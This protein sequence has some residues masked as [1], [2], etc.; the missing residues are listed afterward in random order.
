MATD[1]YYF[2]TSVA[3]PTDPNNAWT[4]DFRAFNG[5]TADNTY[6]NVYGSSNYL[7]GTGTTAPGSGN[8]ITKVEVRLYGHSGNVPNI[9]G[10]IYNGA[11]RLDNGDFE[12]NRVGSAGWGS[13]VELNAPA[14]GGWTWAKIQTLEVRFYRTGMPGI[15][16][17]RKI[18][19]KVTSTFG[20]RGDDSLSIIES[21]ITKLTTYRRLLTD[22]LIVAES[23]A[24]KLTTY[25]VLVSD[26]IVLTESVRIFIGLEVN[27]ADTVA[28]TE[29]VRVAPILEVDVADL[30]TVAESLTRSLSI[31][32]YFNDSTP[33]DPNNVWDNDSS[34]FDGFT[35]TDAIGEVPGSSNYL[36]GT[37]TTS[38]DNGHIIDK[39]E[40]R[41]NGFGEGNPG[42][43]GQVWN[44]PERIDNSDLANWLESQGWGTLAEL[45]IPAVGWDWLRV[46]N[47]EI[48]FYP[49]GAG[50]TSHVYKVE[51]VV[52]SSVAAVE[53]NVNDGVGIVEVILQA[54]SLSLNTNDSIKVTENIIPTIVLAP[55]L[56]E[57][58]SITE[59]VNVQI[60]NVVLEIS[61]FSAVTVTENI[62]LELTHIEVEVVDNLTVAEYL[63]LALSLSVTS[64]DDLSITETLT[65]ILS[66]LKV[67]VND[68]LSI[69]ES[70]T[71]K[72]NILE[73]D[74]F[75]TAVV[76]ENIAIELTHVEVE[77]VD[78]LTVAEYSNTAIS[79]AVSVAESVGIATF[80]KVQ[81]AKLSVNVAD[82]LLVTEILTKNTTVNYYFNDSTPT[83][84]QDVWD[85]DDNAFDGSLS[86][87][88]SVEIPGSS[89]YLSGIGTN[90]I[91]N[92]YSIDKV[93]V[94]IN[95]Y[96]DLNPPVKCLIYAGPE[97]LDDNDIVNGLTEQ[98]WSSFYELNK[99]A[100]GWD[101]SKIQSL[102]V[103]FYK[104]G[105]GGTSY[106][107]KVEFVVTISVTKQL[108]VIVEDDLSVTEIVYPTLTPLK[109]E[110]FDNLSVVEYMHLAPI[111]FGITGVSR[112]IPPFLL[113]TTLLGPFILNTI[114][115]KAPFNF[116]VRVEN[117]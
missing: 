16:S 36:S 96:D 112:L 78:N 4:E 85:N 113:A 64:R 42:I 116:K 102:E 70:T 76:T 97:Q 54:I 115:I 91:S 73:V 83:D 87:R 31:A 30:L 52:T 51:L 77:V 22:T 75:D 40:V 63:K 93:E 72:F 35:F 106:V 7:S 6:A 48:R 9:E 26:S 89:N 37:G 90:A 2:D 45:D 32:F 107:Y 81:L 65:L 50:T 41:I 67:F 10:E 114:K 27:V 57:L 5:S 61:S 59:Y 8:L 47:L 21:I 49:F 11:E 104:L 80:S 79:F 39:V 34:A 95:G 62:T 60:Q 88:A 25:N 82:L 44:G 105:A 84:P 110:I 13:L 53:V 92:E 15:S 19:I 108:S 100:T 117:E 74:K 17:V 23:I 38:P 98:G 43:I 28:V 58:I 12:N 18:E 1:T 94:R 14:S 71:S 3:G 109:I 86:S 46:Q 69:S 55:D 66:L 68:S 103:R 33:Y 111:S 56:D 24:T 20:T 101:W 99:P 29:S